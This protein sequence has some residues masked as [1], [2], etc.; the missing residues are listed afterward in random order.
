MASIRKELRLKVPP[1][2]V[3]DAVRDVGAV[4][5]RLCPGVLT[6]ARLEDD[7]RIV[8]FANG[9]TFRELIVDV[10]DD[11]RR[12]VWAAEGDPLTHH[13]ASMQVFADGDRHTLLVW[14]TDILPN[15]IAGNIQTFINQGAD[16]IRQTLEGQAVAG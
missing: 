5:T 8:T 9:M 3:W 6:N 12:F 14:V 4:H 7:A 10:D 1:E 16:A 11:A 13:N 2:D 15:G